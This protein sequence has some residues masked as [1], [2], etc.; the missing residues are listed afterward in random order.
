MKIN[1]KT[2][3]IAILT[4]F[5]MIISAE[6]FAQFKVSGYFQ[7]QFQY[8]MKD[9][10]LKTGSANE[11]NEHSFNRFGVRRG[12]MKATYAK[13]WASA[14]F[15]LDITEKGLGLK[16]AYLAIDEPYLGIATLKV[17]VFDRPFGYEV[18]YS[19]SKRES[20]ERASV[21][22]TLM[23]E[24]RDLG[25]MIALHAP[26]GTA[27]DFIKMEFG[28]FAGNGIKSETDSRKDFIGRLRA[29]KAV[30]ERWK[31]GG[32]VSYYN[33]R[34]WKGEN[35]YILREYI[36][37]DFQIEHTDKRFGSTKINFEIIAGKQPGN[38]DDN[39]SP[40]SSSLP[41]DGYYDRSRS[42]LGGYVMLV[43][44]LGRLPLSLVV[45]F[46]AFDPNTKISGN[47]VGLNQSGKADVSYRNLGFGMLWNITDNLRLQAFYDWNNNEKT[48]NLN[49]FTADKKDDVFT[50]RLQYK[51]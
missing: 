12:R 35:E 48:E 45:K 15:Q 49:G 36:G 34:V 3:L 14:V 37:A 51:F 19:S 31:L 26:K 44:D 21:I 50:L 20:P 2:T 42:L 25:V 39:K 5:L 43:Q 30:S 11:D 32:G 41:A 1:T 33:G 10:K 8:G 28:L 23:P 9:A 17:G 29:D 38:K 47:E 7:G 46:D 27:L 4:A 6:G 22:Q 40:N 18:G 13:D 16:D 24:E